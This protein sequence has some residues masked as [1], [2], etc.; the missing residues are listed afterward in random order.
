MA[1]S[2]SS[3]GLILF[4]IIV[5]AAG[6]C[7]WYFWQQG[8]DK[9]P[10][11]QTAPVARGDLTQAVSASGT[12]NPV[13]NVQVGSQIS[14]N[15]A[16]LYVDWNSP[17]KQGQLL[18]ELDPSSY[19]LALQQSEGQLANA[20][21]NFAL[22]KATAERQRELFKAHLIPQSD[23]DTAEAQLLQADA[24]VKIQS[25]NHETAKADHVH[26]IVLNSLMS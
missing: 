23:L 25:A 18:A 19:Q 26:I 2:K 7:G 10:E 22:M 14:G 1:K 3:G 6:A 21:A 11:Y 4:I 13:L 16:K 15:I 9:A 12:L 20:N 8:A 5:V 17:V 24:Q